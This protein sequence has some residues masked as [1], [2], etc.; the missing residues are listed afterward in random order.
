MTPSF[1]LSKGRLGQ[2]NRQAV[3]SL[4]DTRPRNV[5]GV[6]VGNDK[7]LHAA[8]IAAVGREA[9]FCL[10][11]ADPGVEEQSCFLRLDIDAV[12]VAAR[13]KRDYCHK[14]V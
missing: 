1:G 6:L 4:Q 11:S 9:L 7:S 8:N 10:N 14:L 13:L 5:I 2:V 12:A 3:L